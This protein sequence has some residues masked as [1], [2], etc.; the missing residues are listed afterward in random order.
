LKRLDDAIYQEKY[1]LLIT[2]H[3]REEIDYIVK[4]MGRV[5]EQICFDSFKRMVA[6]KILQEGTLLF[7]SE[8][9]FH[10]VKRMLREHGITER[11]KDLESRACI[12]RKKAEEYLLN[13][14]PDKIKKENL[15]L[16]YP[17]EESEEF[18]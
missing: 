1:R 4:R 8:E 16:F 9:I 11:I 12:F 18:E 13:E 14:E 7:G 6:C 5:R 3:L 2:P 10:T 17:S 15:Y